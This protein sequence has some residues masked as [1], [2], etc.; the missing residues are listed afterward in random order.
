MKCSDASTLIS[1][2]LDNELTQADAQ[3]IRLH[4]EDC[5]ECGKT[6]QELKTLK[7]KMGQL[8]F[9]A[10]DEEVLKFLEEDPVSLAG[11]W[12]GWLLILIPVIILGSYGFY[13]F[14]TEP[15]TPILIRLL[16]AAFE[17]GMLILFVTVARQ[18]Y[19]SYKTDKYRNVKL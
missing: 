18:R 13:L 16:F 4:I 1:A 11:Q 10:P 9:P 6:Y 3:R 17:L 12:S 5:S 19:F 2:Y 14:V 8:S 15:D 7:Q